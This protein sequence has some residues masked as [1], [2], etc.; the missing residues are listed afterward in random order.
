[1]PAELLLLVSQ[2]VAPGEGQEYSGGGLWAMC[3]YPVL[4]QHQKSGS[5]LLCLRYLPE[6]DRDRARVP[7]AQPVQVPKQ[8]NLRIVALAQQTIPSSGQ[9]RAALQP[10]PQIRPNHL[11]HGADAHGKCREHAAKS[12]RPE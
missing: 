4:H 7:P 12:L 2:L 11:Q 3:S 6:N 5:C 9:R 8:A 10:S 1:M